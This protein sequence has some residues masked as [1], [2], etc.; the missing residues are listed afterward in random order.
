MAYEY[1]NKINGVMKIPVSQFLKPFCRIAI[2]AAIGLS[3][4]E[5]SDTQI[6]EILPFQAGE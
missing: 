3:C 1:V 2:F 5:R 6:V 4:E